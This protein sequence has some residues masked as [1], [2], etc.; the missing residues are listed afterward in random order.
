MFVNDKFSLNRKKILVTGGTGLVG[1][2]VVNG[3]LKAGAELYVV[4]RTA[5]TNKEFKSQNIVAIDLDLST[6]EGVDKLIERVEKDNVQFNGL[7]HAAVFRPGQATLNEPDI[8]FLDSVSKNLRLAYKLYSYFSEAM[9]KNGGGSIVG[10]GSI[11][12]QAAP[13]FDIYTDTN[14]GTEPDY[15][16]IKS[17]L[18]MLA[19]YHAIKHGRRG[20]RI[21][22]LLLG[23]VE[24]KQPKVFI[25]RMIN[26]IP[27]GRMAQPEDCVGPIIFLLS[28]ASGYMTACDIPLEGGYL[29]L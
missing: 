28:D 11:Y 4:G 5:S 8:Y 24:N 29:S 15:P 6:E 22:S 2:S 27:L 16:V 12:G 19:K 25:E 18:S 7:V 13:D 3:L 10:I 17:S 23:G 26:K 14:M 20:V 21:N 1:T 9:A